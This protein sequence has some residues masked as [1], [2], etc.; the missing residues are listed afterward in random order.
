MI[1]VGSSL[2]PTAAYL[3]DKPLKSEFGDDGLKKLVKEVGDAIEKVDQWRVDHAGIDAEDLLG[4]PKI[5][6]AL[7]AKTA[8]YTWEHILK[9]RYSEVRER[10]TE[11]L[12]G[13]LSGSDFSR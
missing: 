6:K 13:K 8:D 11:I 4:D 3:A 5:I 12:V 7:E 10:L 9:T 2:R 1:M